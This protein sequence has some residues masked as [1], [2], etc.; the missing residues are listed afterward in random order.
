MVLVMLSIA[1]NIFKFDTVTMNY[2]VTGYSQNENDWAHS[3]IEKHTKDMTIFTPDQWETAIQMS[4]LKNQVEVHRIGFE[5]IIDFKD[6]TGLHP[7]RNTL[8]SDTKE[9]EDGSKIYWSK[10]MQIKFIQSRP[11]DMLFK[12]SYLVSEYRSAKLAHFA[13]STMNSTSKFYDEP[14]L[15]K[16]YSS[17]LTISDEK[18]QD[19]LQ[20]CGKQLIPAHHHHIYKNLNA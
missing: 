7:Y 9:N 11:L 14:A 18:K 20:L 19:L 8:T 12:Y 17:A 4:F 10:V 2:L 5:D 6:S 3:C 13:T 16:L 1:L 15:P